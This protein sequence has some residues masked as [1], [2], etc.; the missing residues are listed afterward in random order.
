M[1][2]LTG[3]RIITGKAGKNTLASQKGR[4]WYESLTFRQSKIKV[5]NKV[6]DA[7]ADLAAVDQQFDHIG[8][9]SCKYAL[10]EARA[11]LRSYNGSARKMI[12]VGV[13]STPDGF[14]SRTSTI[15]HA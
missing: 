13:S 5:V 2:S 4:P 11:E 8:Y 15:A 10:D 6:L 14:L 3:L 7:S 9:T 1:F 12:F